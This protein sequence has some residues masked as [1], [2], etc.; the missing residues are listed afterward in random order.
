MP[1]KSKRRNHVLR[2]STALQS[3]FD[4]YNAPPLARVSAIRNASNIAIKSNIARKSNIAKASRS[5]KP[6]S[7]SRLN[8]LLKRLKNGSKSSFTRRNK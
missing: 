3:F 8:N 7:V 2:V 5:E 4:G 6:V 1:Q